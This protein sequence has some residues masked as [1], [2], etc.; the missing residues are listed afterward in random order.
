MIARKTPVKAPGRKGAARATAAV[1]EDDV[2]DRIRG[3]VLDHRLEPGTKLKEV[4]LAEVFGVN[5]NVVRKVLQRLT[6]VMNVAALKTEGKS[7]Q[8]SQGIGMGK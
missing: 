8:R 5:R 3:A 2:Y 6:P 1:S 7:L 4:A